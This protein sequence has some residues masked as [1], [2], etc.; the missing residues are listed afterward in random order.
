MATHEPQARRRALRVM[1]WSPVMTVSAAWLVSAFGIQWALESR[2][3]KV[4]LA[5]GNFFLTWQLPTMPSTLPPNAPTKDIMDYGNLA[6][7]DRIMFNAFSGNGVSTR[8]SAVMYKPGFKI[9][10]FQGL[11]VLRWTPY[12]KFSSY[13]DSYS[14]IIPLYIPLLIFSLMPAIFILRSTLRQRDRNRCSKC[15]YNLTGNQSGKCPEC[16][17]PIVGQT[18]SDEQA[19]STR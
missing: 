9:F 15:D 19:M 8:C 18:A 17:Q 11:G 2:R 13:T 7:C 12:A 1:V 3:Q 14:F 6:P 10:G 4:M 5:S 16:G